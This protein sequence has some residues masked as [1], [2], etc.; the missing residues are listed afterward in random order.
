MV[1]VSIQMDDWPSSETLLRVAVGVMAVTGSW[2]VVIAGSLVLET[3]E[4]EIVV[5]SGMAL[6][7]DAVD[8]GAEGVRGGRVALPEEPIEVGGRSV[9]VELTGGIS[10][11]DSESVGGVMVELGGG[12]VVGGTL[13]LVSLVVVELVSMGGRE[14]DSLVGGSV[15]LGSELLGVEVITG[16]SEVEVWETGGT[17]ELSDTGGTEDVSDTMG[18]EEVSDTMGP[19]EVSDTM[20]PEEVSDTMGPEEVSDTMGPE[21]VSDTMGPEEVSDTMGPDEVSETMGPDEVSEAGGAEEV[22]ETVG[23][24]ELV[25]VEEGVGRRVGRLS[26][27]KS[28]KLLLV[29]EGSV[30]DEVELVS[31]SA[32]TEDEM[33]VLEAVLET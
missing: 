24:E 9:E 4:V 6:V 8:E 23:S 21:E 1:V 14:L 12:R 19:E 5:G 26:V 3:T 22:S 31:G 17:E 28:I 15:E 33:M 11:L 30:M 18:P 2:V 13:T 29:L 10:V 16:G 20:G 25:S 27:G 7:S 32:G